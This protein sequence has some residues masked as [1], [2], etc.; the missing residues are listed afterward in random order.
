[1]IATYTPEDEIF[2]KDYLPPPRKNKLAAIKAIELPASFL[3]GLPESKKRKKRHGLKMIGE[4]VHDQKTARL[5]QLRKDLG[6]LILHQ[7]EKAEKFKERW[8]PLKTETVTKRKEEE[9]RQVAA[10][11]TAGGASTAHS[12][13]SKDSLSSSM[14]Q[15]Q[16]SCSKG[17]S[18]HHH[19]H[20]GCS[21]S[22]HRDNSMSG[23]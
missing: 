15:P 13:K 14:I 10:S 23:F 19:Q 1:M 11:G 17:S 6:D 4:G 5:K 8:E 2:K 18:K 9:K 3:E 12:S 21:P 16:S 20:Q 22:K 7:E